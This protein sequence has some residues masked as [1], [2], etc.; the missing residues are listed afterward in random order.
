MMARAF[1]HFCSYH[2]YEFNG[3]I[4]ANHEETVVDEV[5][6]YVFAALGCIFQFS[7]SFKVPF[8][9]NLVLWPANMAEYYIRWSISQKTGVKA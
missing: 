1:C 4:K 3:L 8:P 6:S 7:M 9:L 5:L 2:G